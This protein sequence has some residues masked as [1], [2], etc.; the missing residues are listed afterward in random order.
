MHSIILLRSLYIPTGA[1]IR[2]DAA[3]EKLREAASQLAAAEE[4]EA[5]LR[6]RLLDSDNMQ[7][8]AALAQE[9]AAAAQKQLQ[10]LQSSHE[11]LS[12]KSKEAS[13][14]CAALQVLPGLLQTH[15]ARALGLQ[16]S[17]QS[18][19]CYMSLARS[20]LIANICC[21][22][23]QRLHPRFMHIVRISLLPVQ[24]L[25]LHTGGGTQAG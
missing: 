8:Q 10:L 20:V 23:L 15:A 18:Q 25:L 22:A 21:W 13:D 6:S 24:D 16:L 1:Q 14:R 2:A 12:A 4:R 19:T 9:G 17:V 7:G 11:D 3:E 5:E